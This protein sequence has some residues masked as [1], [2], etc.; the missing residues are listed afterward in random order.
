[1]HAAG[2]AA[3]LQG[4]ESMNI[5]ILREFIQVGLQLSISKAAASMHIS[6]PTLSKHIA[7]LEQECETPLLERTPTGVAL[8]PAGKILFEEAFGLVRSYDVALKRV[9][10]LKQSSTIKLSGLFM[11]STISRV[12]NRAVTRINNEGTALTI[13]CEN[14]TDQSRQEIIKN[15][16]ADFVFTI[17]AEGEDIPGCDKAFLF[18]EPMVCLV[19]EGHPFAIKERLRAADLDGQAVLQPVG[20]YSSEHGRTTATQIF[21]AHK[22][23]PREHATFVHNFMDL[24]G[25]D[26]TSAM[27][28]ME[29]SLIDSVPVG[30]GYIAREFEEEDLRFGFYVLYDKSALENPLKKQFLEELL[31]D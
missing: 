7:M 28:I 15:G 23:N 26:N 27:L 30:S 29:S 6:Q 31:R 3:R 4:V 14:H 11:N 2:L 5:S 10:S 17:L 20:S 22:I 13:V 25:V 21:R 1:M 19:K 8:T 16:A 9:R 18:Y 12:V 24:F